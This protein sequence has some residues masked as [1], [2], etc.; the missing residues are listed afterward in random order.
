MED[1]LK[2]FQETKFEKPKGKNRK[3]PFKILQGDCREQLSNLAAN[4]IDCCITSP[5][6]WSLRDYGKN[7]Q[8]GLE[9]TPE[10]YIKEMV[11]VFKAVHRVL[12]PSGSLWINIGDSYISKDMGKYKTKDLAGIP[13]SLVFALRDAGW[14]WRS[15][16]IWNKTRYMPESAKDRPA[17]CHEY[18]F[19]L[20]KSSK[21][22]Y[23]IDS[24]RVPYAK[25]TKARRKYVHNKAT[26]NSK[27]GWANSKGNE[28][29]SMDMLE[30]NPKG[31]NNSTIWDI[32]PVNF[33]G[34][35]FATYPVSLIEPCVLAGSPP[36]GIVLDPFNGSGTTGVAALKHGRSYVGI[37]LNPEYIEISRKRILSRFFV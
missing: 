32:S 15:E 20:T 16:I 21:Y 1:L 8:V 34:M 13:H 19:L 3:E 5:P 35:H 29:V 28:D 18:I 37:E 14:Y 23:D 17:R 4:S 22:Y 12:K 33:P 26:S 36:S 25:A 30:M 27:G 11:K 10:K 9:D 24:V 31:K 6:Y 2:I 7:D